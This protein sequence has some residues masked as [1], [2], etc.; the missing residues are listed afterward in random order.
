MAEVLQSTPT[1][2][3]T[4]GTSARRPDGP[5]KAAGEFAFAGDLHAEGMLWGATVRSPHPSALIRSVDVAPAWQLPGVRA[6]L[7]ADDVPG[8]LEFGVNDPD[9]PVLA[10]GR[11]R[12]VGEPVAV[13]AA[14][15]PLTALRAA[16]AN[17][18]PYYPLVPLLVLEQSVRAPPTVSV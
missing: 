12:Y 2:A 15:D 8:R 3:G 16:A 4:V 14:D 5:A 7:L 1:T 9:Q 11:V 6:V 10:A 13:V 17:T 18:V